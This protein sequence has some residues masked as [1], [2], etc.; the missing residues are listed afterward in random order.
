MRFEVVL[1]DK[2]YLSD[3]V[4]SITLEDNLSEISYRAEITLELVNN[5]P[6][7]LAIGKNI[8]ISGTPYGIGEMKPFLAFGIIWS[9]ETRKSGA[10]EL[11]LTIYDKSIY[12]KSEDEYLFQAGLTAS[13]RLKRYLQDVKLPVGE[14]KNTGVKLSQKLY[15][16]QSIYSM[17]TEDLKETVA[18]GGDMY[19]VYMSPGGI[20]LRKIGDNDKVF[21][22]STDTQNV[23][24][25][26]QSITLENLVSKVKVLGEAPDDMKSPVLAVITGDTSFGIMQKIIQEDDIQNKSEAEQKARLMLNT[27]DETFTFT[28]ICIPQLRA[29]DLI[30]LNKMELIA[31]EVRHEFGQVGRTTITAGSKEYV[32]RTYYV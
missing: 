21:E 4:K 13:D 17:I 15:G 12:L 14:I 5:L 7:E 10:E 26:T 23:F 22:F 20:A 11:S 3:I 31:V 32:R 30:K 25:L 24:E 18:K 19:R 27:L 2:Y 29:G 6:G 28:T 8:R 9:R 16:A 1:E